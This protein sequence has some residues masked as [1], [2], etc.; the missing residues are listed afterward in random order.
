MEQIGVYEG[1]CNRF[2]PEVTSD[3]N[4]VRGTY[5]RGDYHARPHPGMDE[6]DPSAYSDDELGRQ[7]LLVDLHEGRRDWLKEK[8]QSLYSIQRA[9]DA[10]QERATQGIGRFLGE[11]K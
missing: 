10:Y 9:N 2:D 8:A 11:G 4:R 5:H 6:I 7:R 3:W 1:L